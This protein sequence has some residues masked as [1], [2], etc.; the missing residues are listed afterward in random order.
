MHKGF[1]AVLEKY[2]SFCAWAEKNIQKTLWGAAL[3]I[4]LAL[5]F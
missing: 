4:V 5:V 1:I 2:D 3:L